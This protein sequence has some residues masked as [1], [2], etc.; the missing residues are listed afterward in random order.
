M[1]LKLY[2][3]DWCTQCNNVKDMLMQKGL[4]YVV[5]DVDEN[6]EEMEALVKQG[7]RGLPVMDV[8][9]DLYVGMK[10]TLEFINAK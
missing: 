10:G 8:D 2:S 1:P 5:V 6:P 4:A 9:G 7:I 3:A